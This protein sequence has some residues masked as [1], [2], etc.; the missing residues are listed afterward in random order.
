MESIRCGSCRRLLCRAAERAIAGV[1]EIKCPRCGTINSLRPTS[2]Q[3]ER[4]P[5]RPEKDKDACTGSSTTP[6]PSPG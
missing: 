4:R 1:V 6:T 5:E 3:P 2:P